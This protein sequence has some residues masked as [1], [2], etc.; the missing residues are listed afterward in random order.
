MKIVMGTAGS[1]GDVQPM[2]VLAKAL[3]QAGHEVVLAAPEDAT[4]FVQDHGVTYRRLC[5]PFDKMMPTGQD[6]FRAMF[7]AVRLMVEEQLDTFPQIARGA[8]LLI[9]GSGLFCGWSVAE[10][11]G[12]PLRSIIYCPRTIPSSFHPSVTFTGSPPRWINRFLWWLN[13]VSMQ[14][15]VGEPVARWRAL[16]QLGRRFKVYRELITERPILAADPLLG[17]LPEDLVSRTDQ[18]GAFFLDDPQPLP[19]EL[20]DFLARGEQPIY[21]GFGSVKDAD[22]E[23]TTS[24][25]VEAARLAK[26]RVVL[27]RGWAGFGAGPLPDN[28]LAIGPVAHNMLLPRMRALVHHGGAGTTHA[29]TR[30]GIPQVVIPHFFD[31]FYWGARV[32]ALGIAPAPI[33]KPKLNPKRLAEALRWCLSIGAREQ[34]QE[35]ATWIHTDG[36]QRAVE[37]LTGSRVEPQRLRI[38]V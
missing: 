28:V 34:A 36:T 23:R 13:D 7:Q 4:Q 1:R 11:L 26:V 16:H 22:P 32:H 35:V 15:I 29:A 31:Q 5:G 37:L 6:E 19:A 3:Q 10:S 30:A 2:V 8:D 20:E 17:P 33:P 9:N 24:L 25:F 18:V 27:L 12:I 21:I 14:R 38:A